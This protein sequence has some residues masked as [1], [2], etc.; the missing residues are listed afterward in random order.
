MVSTKDILSYADSDTA[1]LTATVYDDT[2]SQLPM[3]GQTVTLK[4][5]G[6]TVKTDTT[7]SNGEISY[8]Y[9]STGAGDVTIS[10]ECGLVTETY[11]IEDC[12]Y[13]SDNMQ[14]IKTTFNVDTSVSGRTIYSSPFTFNP[15]IEMLY[16]FK[17]R[18]K[19]LIRMVDDSV[20]FPD[21]LENIK[22]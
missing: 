8:T 10:A 9:S 16:K 15:N 22:F 12:L 5:N 7:D 6:T 3:S 20:L 4:V 1:T 14:K 21:L 17:N 19:C 18:F 2:A 13:Y 11:G